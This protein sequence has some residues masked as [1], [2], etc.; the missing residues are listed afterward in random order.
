MAQKSVG[1]ALIRAPQL[2]Q[3]VKWTGSR[4]ADRDAGKRAP[5]GSVEC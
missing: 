4:S 3:N 2:W 1:A 5:L